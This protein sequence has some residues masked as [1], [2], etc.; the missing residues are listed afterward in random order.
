MYYV[1]GASAPKVFK[2]TSSVYLQNLVNVYRDFGFLTPEKILRQYFGHGSV[3]VFRDEIK[4]YNIDSYITPTYIANGYHRPEE[5][6]D[7]NGDCI[8][9]SRKMECLLYENISN[10]TTEGTAKKINR[11]CQTYLTKKD[12]LLKLS[13]SKVK[14]CKSNLSLS[15]FDRCVIRKFYPYLM[16][17][18]IVSYFIPGIK[19]SAISK[20]A[21]RLDMSKDVSKRLTAKQFN[22]FV[23][24]VKTS[25]NSKDIHRKF[26]QLPFQV[27]SELI[28][29]IKTFVAN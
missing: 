3:E 9:W 16:N 6:K 18:S 2:G 29:Y 28:F 8:L 19:E 7:S 1:Y 23:K 14:Q 22:S 21:N 26:N 12:I 11:E 13:E 27:V 25:A 5:T 17:S 4:H 10:L 20:Y 15:E 24:L